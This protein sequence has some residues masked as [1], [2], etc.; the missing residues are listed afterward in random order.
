MNRFFQGEEFFSGESVKRAKRRF[1]SGFQID[2]VVV[3]PVRRQ[4]LSTGLFEQW[5]KVVIFLRYQSSDFVFLR[6][7]TG[8]VRGL[9]EGLK[10]FL[11]RDASREFFVF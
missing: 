1:K 6:V 9:F 11:D 2:G 4:S 5:Y 7:G 8:L 10:Q 3:F